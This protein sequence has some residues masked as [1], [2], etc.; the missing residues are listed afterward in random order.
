MVVYIILPDL[1]KVF[2]KQLDPV[3]KFEKYKIQM[4]KKHIICE[5]HKLSI[6]SAY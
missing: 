6:V 4:V 5:V 3:E 1:S 2:K